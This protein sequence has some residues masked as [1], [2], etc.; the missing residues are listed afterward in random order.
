[1]S[2]RL[3]VL[4]SSVLL[5]VLLTVPHGMAQDCNQSTK[6]TSNDAADF[7]S[8]GSSVSLSGD[9]VLVG[10]A[11]DDDHGSQTGSAYIFER[12]A[13]GV[14][15]WGQVAKL[16]ITDAA[17]GDNTGHSVSLSGNRA[18]VGAPLT[19]DGGFGSGSAY[20]FERDAG[21][22]GNWGQVA[23]LTA[24]DAATGDQF[25][26]SVSLSGDRALVG[27]YGDDDDGSYSGSAYLFERDAGGEGNWGQVAKL[28]ASDA[29][30]EDY[31]GWSV[32][33]SGNR[34]LVG[35]N[36]HDEGG[37]DSGSACLFERDA[38]G[39]GNWGQ[40]AKLTATDATEGDWFGRSVSLSGERALVAAPNDDDGGLDSGSAYLFERNAGG[41]TDWALVAK[42]T[43][44][45]AAAGDKFG[46]SVS[47]SGERVV[48]GANLDDGGGVFRSGSAYVFERDPRGVG[49]WVQ[50][51]KLTA[52]DAAATDS[53]GD[54]V[55][56][57]AN[58]VIVG[59]VGD[60]DGGNGSGSAYTFDCSPL[61]HARFQALR[62]DA[63]LPALA[64]VF[65][66]PCTTLSDL[67]ICDEA[68][69]IHEPIVDDPILPLSI[70]PADA[71]GDLVFMEYDSDTVAAGSV[72]SIGVAKDPMTEGGL[73]V[74][75]R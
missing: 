27:A 69:G 47:L 8:F 17:A 53:F 31:F 2:R 24:T 59:A 74:S 28:T 49:T 3:S 37:L 51:A 11:G 75:L 22:A 7:D 66:T 10:A 4:G 35:A 40:V 23:N 42:L 33:L 18:L 36:L 61:L 12:D 41:A 45:D 16:T 50:V 52:T 65:G 57:S 9:R 64:V 25:G 73:I 13:G 29:A 21:G 56:L 46:D 30:R 48:V 14:G 67:R 71:T 54:S 19:D 1:M 72:D 43:A 34:A 6:F 55:S 62:L 39:V 26:W 20:V 60:D 58:R 63:P 44:T 32:S 15:N 5:L 68:P 38:G 70:A